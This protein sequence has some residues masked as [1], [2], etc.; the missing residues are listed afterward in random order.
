MKRI[1][2]LFCTV[3]LFICSLCGCSASPEKNPSIPGGSTIPGGNTAKDPD[4]KNTEEAAFAALQKKI[5]Q[6]GS[7]VAVAF[8]GYVD[9]ESSEVDLRAFLWESPFSYAYDFLVDASLVMTEGQEFYAILPPCKAGTITICSSVLN[10]AGEYIDDFENPLFVGEPG[11]P[12]LLLCNVSEIYSNVIITATD[13]GG[14]VRFR[15]SVS[16]ENGRIDHIPEIYDFTMYEWEPGE[17]DVEIATELLSE[18]DA[19][20]TALAQGMK[21]MYTGDRQLIDGHTCLLFALGTDHG[22]QFVREQLYGVCD[23]LIYIHDAE[24]TEWSP[25]GVPA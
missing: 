8:I 18:L 22:D 19:V 9:S 4:D 23:N 15:P 24:S 12:V 14:A 6:S 13:G 1:V 21:L 20:K 10:D 25:V 16:L 11:E 2:L 3:M 17:R 7:A 5:A